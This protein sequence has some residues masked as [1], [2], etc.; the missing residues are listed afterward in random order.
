[1]LY[2]CSPWMPADR[3]STSTCATGEQS[4]NA[5]ASP[6]DPARPRSKPK[7]PPACDR[8]KVR[9]LSSALPDGARKLTLQLCRLSACSATRAR[10]VALVA[11][12]PRYCKSRQHSPRTTSCS[13]TFCLL[14]RCTTTPVARKKPQ[15]RAR[16]AASRA[17]PSASPALVPAPTFS[18]QAA[19]TTPSTHDFQIIASTS[20]P[21]RVLVGNEPLFEL[22]DSIVD[23]LIPRA[24]SLSVAPSVL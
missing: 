7:K 2:V 18:T 17:P 24:S 8:C 16:T 4:R 1:M 12:R 5:S 10:R 22:S 20:R 23:D 6:P 21:E 3:S 9:R 11:S 15:G 14:R 13:L 19:S